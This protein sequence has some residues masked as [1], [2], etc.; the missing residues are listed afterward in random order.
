VLHFGRG[1]VGCSTR[2]F[3]QSN[4]GKQQ[5]NCPDDFVP[6]GLRRRYHAQEPWLP[7]RAVPQ[8]RASQRSDTIMLQY[9]DERILGASGWIDIFNDVELSGQSKCPH[10]V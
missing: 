8:Q 5:I 6:N 3:E 2:G 10:A 7:Q 4:S 1:A 9:D